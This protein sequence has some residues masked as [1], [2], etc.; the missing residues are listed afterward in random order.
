MTRC[1]PV[2][3]ADDIEFPYGGRRHYADISYWATPPPVFI[4]YTD[5]TRRV[6]REYGPW[7]CVLNPR[8]ES[9]IDYS[10][11]ALK[12]PEKERGADTAP[13][14]YLA[15]LPPVFSLYTDR[16]FIILAYVRG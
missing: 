8:Y 12:L 7:T 16:N 11:F 9:E 5:R 10:T 3:I 15:A 1:I 4:L 14:S 2:L 13:F 6:W